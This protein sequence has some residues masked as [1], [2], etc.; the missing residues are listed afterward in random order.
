MKAVNKKSRRGFTLVEV[1]VVIAILI[2][3]GALVFMG[4]GKAT[5][6]A[7]KTESINNIK[8]LSAISVADAGD[9]GG[10]FPEV[11]Y[12]NLPFWFSQVWRD[13]AGITREMAYC[14]A[15]ECWTKEGRDICATPKLDLWDYQGTEESSIFGYACLTYNPIWSEQ[16]SFAQPDNWT[17][18]EKRVRDQ[19][20]EIRWVPERTTQPDV[21]YPI[22]WIDIATTWNN[23]IIGNFMKNERD[24]E[25]THVGYLDGHVE[26]VNAK[27]MQRRFSSPGVSL[28]W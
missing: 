17:I 5:T 1:L 20:G 22:L 7:R 21:A 16:G 14:S 11:H 18:I 25:G 13:E 24:F 19:D 6:A 28:F 15:N 8:Q 2:T 26:W 12:G 23:R 27:Q 3:L 10:I 9:N 4:I